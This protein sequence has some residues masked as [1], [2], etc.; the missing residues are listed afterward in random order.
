MGEYPSKVYASATA[1]MKHIEEIDDHDTVA[2]HFNFPS[3]GMA[4]IDLSR[5]SVYGYDQSE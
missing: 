2:I 1:H 5:F 4:C 3:G